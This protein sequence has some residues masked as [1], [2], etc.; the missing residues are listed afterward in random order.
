MAFPL[1]LKAIGYG[2]ATF[3]AGTLV[4]SI[5]GTVAVSVGTSSI[6]KSGWSFLAILSYFVPITAGFV[7]AYFAPAK[8][9][10]HGTIGGAVGVLLLLALPFWC[11]GIPWPAFPSSSHGM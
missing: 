1:N 6:G 9:V 5:V 11:L 10:L 8:R 2:F 4:L 3:V 7:A